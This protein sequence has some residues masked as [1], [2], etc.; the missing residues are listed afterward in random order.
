M[1]F[2]IPAELAAYL[3]ELDDFIER[4]IKPL[5]ATDDNIRFFDHRREHARTD[6][7]NGGRPREEWEA[8]L[9]EAR[10]RADAAGH[11]R[12][13][14]PKAFG[15]RDG[16]NL[17]MA[18]IR[19][20]LASRGLGLHCDLQNEHAIVA[21][22]IG[23]LLML[24]YGSEAQKEAW[25]E[26][27]ATGQGFMAFGITEPDHGSDATHMETTAVRDGDGWRINGEKTWNTGIHTA[28][29][30]L[31]FA[32]TSG[33][34]GDGDGIT[35]FI[36]PTDSPGFRLEELLWTFNMPTDHGHITL[37]DVRVPDSAIFGGEG[38]GL[39]VVQHFFNENR[40][41]QAASSLGAAQFC[42]NEAVAYARERKPF[43]K[44]L[45]SNQGIQFPLVELQTQCEML[46]ALVHKTAWMMDTYGAFSVSDKV[47]MCNYW[48]NRLCCEAADRAMQVH[49]GMGY[50]RH[51]PFEH[52]YRHH[53]RYRITEGA[54]EIQMRRVA[55]YM[56]GFM[57]Q[58]APK[59]VRD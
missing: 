45:A 34:A 33:K 56:F 3:Q 14:F 59:G 12:Y 37:R 28:P 23:L 43:G 15:G 10:R 35:A 4:E 9:A 1:N 51:K 26:P 50:S 39:Q 13:A 49:G 36:V 44:P 17:G 19:E 38:R 16:T 55:G 5:E 20:H 18:I 53:R 58:R 32:R 2:D 29:A 30:D 6:W 54:E 52:I 41:R 8:L 7:D 57:K 48:G 27:L 24:E 22:N 11:F 40:I 21:N 47:S 46:R 25:V 31:I 42:I